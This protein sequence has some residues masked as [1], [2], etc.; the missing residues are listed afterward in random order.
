MAKPPW[1]RLTNPIKPMVTDRPTETMNNT[2]P[3]ATPP[4]IMLA[5][6]MPKITS[7]PSPRPS[8][9]GTR[10]DLLLL[11]GVLHPVDL[12]DR[13]LDD[14][15]VLHDRLG[16]VLV[17]HDVA[18][19]WVDHDGT[20]RTVEFPALECLECLVRIDRALEGLDHVDDGRHTIVAAHVHEVGRG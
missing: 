7:G 14:A 11:A 13:L 1:A 10:A 17:H 20:A 2:M 12:A 9:G 5:R 18:G 6:S 16:Q 19:D 8:L 4:R 3:A 15:A